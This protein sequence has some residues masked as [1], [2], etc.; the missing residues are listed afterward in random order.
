MECVFDAKTSAYLPKRLVLLTEHF[1]NEFF[2][3]DHL[4]NLL[5]FKLLNHNPYREYF[6]Q[7]YPN[8]IDENQLTDEMINVFKSYTNSRTSE[9][10]KKTNLSLLSANL[11]EIDWIYVNRLRSLIRSLV[12][13]NIKHCYYRGLT[14][15]DREIQYYLNRRHQYYFTN[16]F[17]SF[18]TDRLLVYPGNALIFLKIDQ[19]SENAKKNIAN[20]WQWSEYPDEKEALLAVGSKLKVLSVY[21]RGNK[22]EI[23]VELVDD[24][25]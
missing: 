25:D 9:Q 22:W 19:T 10:F 4:T 2:D 13:T 8:S 21:H 7:V 17:T 15:S 5:S 18:T 14:L 16:S 24:S 12:Q 20:I 23:E 3:Y 6:V 1:E 11:G